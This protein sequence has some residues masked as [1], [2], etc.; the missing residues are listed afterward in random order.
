MYRVRRPGYR[1]ERDGVRHLRARGG[2]RRKERQE[3]KKKKRGERERERERRDNVPQG[4]GV[5]HETTKR[6]RAGFDK[7]EAEATEG[8]RAGETTGE[9]G[10]DGEGTDKRKRGH[11]G[12]TLPRVLL[13]LLASS[14]RYADLGL[15]VRLRKCSLSLS[16]CPL[17]RT[18]VRAC[19]RACLPACV[20]AYVYLSCYTVC[21]NTGHV[22]PLD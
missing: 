8:R 19:V 3:R 22:W 7:S 13:P 6:A 1:V 2:N 4:R 16:V 18:N 5:A 14:N 10:R 9:R 12:V 17:A 20:R 21:S 15:P 11:S